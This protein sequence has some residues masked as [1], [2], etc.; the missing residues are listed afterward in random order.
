MAKNSWYAWR[1]ADG[2]GDVCQTWDECQN[3]SS[4][5][6]GEKHKGFKTYEEAWAFAHPDQPVPEQQAAQPAPQAAVT[7][8]GGQTMR[9]P[10]QDVTGSAPPWDTSD[11]LTDNRAAISLDASKIEKPPVSDQVNQFCEHYGFPH[12]S[13]DQRRAVQA[14]EGKY[15]LF[16]V[17]GSGKTTVLMAR[18]GY[19]IHGCGIPPGQLMTMTFTRASAKEMRDR[20]CKYFPGREDQIP[21]F[22]T[23]HSFCYSIVIP[24][25]RKA[26][27]ICPRH[28]VNE[29]AEEPT[30]KKRYAQRVI[31][32]TVLKKQKN[33]P[34]G[35]ANDET[36]QEAV[37]TAFSSI[38]NREMTEAEYSRYSVKIDKVPYPLAPLFRDYQELLGQLDCLD[39]DDMLVYALKGLKEFPSVV[40]A[41]QE[42]YH[43]WSIDEAQDNSKIQHELMTLLA[44]PDGNLFMVGDDDQSIYGF[45]GAEPGMLL[46]FGNRPDVHLL[47]MGTNYRSDQC[48]VTTAKPFVEINKRRADKSMNASHPEPGEMLIPPS[49][50]TE[51]QQYEYIDKAVRECN[52]NK[53]KLGILYQLN[54]SALPLIV[55]MHRSGSPFEASKGLSE[56]LHR[57]TVGNLMQIIRFSQHPC[58]MERFAECRKTLGLYWMTEDLMKQ[59]KD[60]HIRNKQKPLLQIILESFE[61][62]NERSRKVTELQRIM[63]DIREMKP[64]DAL[65]CLLKSPETAPSSEI[66]TDRLAQYALLSVCDL[67]DSIPEM[68]EELAAMEQAEKRKDEDVPEEEKTEE[69]QGV[70]TAGKPLITLSTIHSAK[71][72]E[73][74]RVI[75]IDSFQET[76]PGEPQFDRIG[77]DPEEARRVFYVAVTRAIHR[78]E[79]LTVGQWHGNRETVS[80]FIPEFAFLADLKTDETAT[81]KTITEESVAGSSE[82]V[83]QPTVF[84]GVPVGRVPG[85]YTD[86]KDVEAQ[87]NGVSM[88]AD[89]RQK[90]F[91]SYEEAWEY[92][93]VR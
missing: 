28:V 40:R 50:P 32:A 9:A 69:D 70:A 27:F 51:A 67:Y 61:E 78:L 92:L 87:I 1:D 76:F 36:V 55:H 63:Q 84:Y 86:Y 74:D 48:I 71:G 44:G 59:L 25:L 57:R 22:R 79:I 46:A 4:G 24:M 72:R 37:Q 54:I 62:E 56:L 30:Q 42:K 41:L 77:Y 65:I 31:L 6:R 13:A 58:S 23:I 11:Q 35:K 73:W 75:L 10:V 91:A 68:L 20:Y 5:K 66:L 47:V 14:A 43:Y 17:P 60:I 33:F 18:T 85:V 19:L 89:R 88:P 80:S 90:K 45:R 49:F 3:A 53:T 7:A 38:K 81:E 26:G 83:F 52:E 34:V 12:L 39:F 64:S 2:N 21:D 16:A 15:L 93:A 8:A 82:Y 29:A